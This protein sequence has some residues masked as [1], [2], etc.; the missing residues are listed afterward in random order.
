METNNL[1][2]TN[3]GFT[4]CKLFIE[5]YLSIEKDIWGFPSL[6]IFNSIKYSISISYDRVGIEHA[7]SSYLQKNMFLDKDVC[8]IISKQI[9]GEIYDIYKKTILDF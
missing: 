1:I 7:I 4:K 5:N 6:V 8:F 2:I 3:K 9:V